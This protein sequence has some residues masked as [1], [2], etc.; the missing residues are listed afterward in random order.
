MTLLLWHWWPFC[1][2]TDLTLLPWQWCDPFVLTAMWSLCLDSDVTP[3]PWQRCDPFALTAMWPFALTMMS[4]QWW[5]NW[6]F[7]IYSFLTSSWIGLARKVYLLHLRLFVKTASKSHLHF[8]VKFRTLGE[9]DLCHNG[10]RYQ[11]KCVVTSQIWWQRSMVSLCKIPMQIFKKD[12][13]FFIALHTRQRWWPVTPQWVAV[14]KVSQKV[15][16]LFL[17]E[18]SM[19]NMCPQH[20]VCGL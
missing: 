17:R 1:L 2:D 5:L 12:Y 20:T 9:N 8:P 19:K 11:A 4:K 14:Q 18:I 7:T 13:V 16:K 3:L 15:I 6:S 10:R